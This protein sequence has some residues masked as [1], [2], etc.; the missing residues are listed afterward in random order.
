MQIFNFIKHF[1]IILF[2]SKFAKIKFDVCCE[3]ILFMHFTQRNIQTF[4]Q[5]DII[6]YKYKSLDCV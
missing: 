5:S 2:F 4:T 6:C 3:Y 1:R